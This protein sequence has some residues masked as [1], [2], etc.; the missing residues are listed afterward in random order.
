MSGNHPAVLDHAFGMAVARAKAIFVGRGDVRLQ[1]IGWV[2][3]LT[4]ETGHPMAS[5]NQYCLERRVNA[6][7]V[8][9]YPIHLFRRTAAGIGNPHNPG[10]TARWR[11]VIDSG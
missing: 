11:V 4:G 10:A 3:S 2:E 7:C 6:I 1:G 8:T 5:L 9:R